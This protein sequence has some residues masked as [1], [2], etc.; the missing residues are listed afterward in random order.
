MVPVTTSNTDGSSSSAS[1]TQRLFIVVHGD[2]SYLY[3]DRDG[4]PHEAD[5]ETL[6][7]A[8]DAAQ[9]LPRAE[10]FIFHQRSHDPLFGIFP[11]DDGTFYHFRRGEL[12]HQNTYR[13]TRSDSLRAEAALVRSHRAPAPDSSLFT[14]ALYYGHAVPERPRSGYH[15]SRPGAAF[16][17][18]ALVEG[19]DRLHPSGPFDAVVLSTCNGGAPP[20]VTAVAPHTRTLLASPGDLHLSFIDADILSALA[21]TDTPNAWTGQFAERAFDRL[22]D[23]VTTAV[24]LATYDLDQAAS[25]ARR[26]ARTVAPDTSTT[27]T[28]ARHVDCREVMDLP[29]DT[30]GVEVWHRPAQFGPQ[31]DRNSHSGWGCTQA[32]ARD[33]AGPR[34]SDGDRKTP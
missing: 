5:V 28:G 17:M 33:G 3:H 12:Q 9:S 11:R 31:A 29:V 18:R 25:A 10:V 20:S 6:Q 15:R 7:E 14:A 34:R 30:T 1:L 8:F 27:P 32:S 19:L 21:P 13:Q 23:R 2:A 16:G 4:T 26:M 22:Q 24:T